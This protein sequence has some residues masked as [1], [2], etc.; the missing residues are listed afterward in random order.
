MA[1]TDSGTAARESGIDRAIIERA[2][3]AVG[4]PVGELCDALVVLHAELIG[5]HSEFERPRDYV[6]VDGT[7]A[8][9]VPESRF[10]S[11]LDSFR[12]DPAERAAIEYAHTE[13]AKLL[14][15]SAVRGDDNFDRDE[16]GVV[17]GI[18]TAEQF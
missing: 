3:D 12:F 1:T 9:R 7:R 6:T 13:Q 16:V 18:D 4:L 17:V 8:Y 10:E 5:R 2:A 14:F 15:A 11:L